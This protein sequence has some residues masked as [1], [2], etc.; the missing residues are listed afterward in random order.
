MPDQD[1]RVAGKSTGV[2]LACLFARESGLRTLEHLSALPSFHIQGIY[3]H[4][5]EPDGRTR[6]EEYPRYLAW[7]ERHGV[8]IV[9]CTRRQEGLRALVEQRPDFIVSLCYRYLVPDTIL[10]TARVAAM[11]IHRS[12]LPLFPGAKPLE[13]ALE[14]GETK[15]GITIHRMTAEFDKGEILAQAAVPILPGDTVPVLFEKIYPLHGPLL[16]Q[17]IRKLSAC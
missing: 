13:R 10:S 12:L 2:S 11:N 7:A 16:E 6:R 4:E 14:A 17:V 8:P 3:T 15:T 1:P 5:F 9:V